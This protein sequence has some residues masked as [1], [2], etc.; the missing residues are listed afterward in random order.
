M[1]GISVT[2]NVVP[3]AHVADQIWVGE[4]FKFVYSLNCSGVPCTDRPSVIP[5][6]QPKRNPNIFV[7]I[8]LTS[9]PPTGLIHVVVLSPLRCCGTHT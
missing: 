6:P 9:Q 4:I 7:N 1:T 5:T 2:L 8:K 3:D